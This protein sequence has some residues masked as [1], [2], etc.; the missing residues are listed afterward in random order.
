MDII[1][2]LDIRDADTAEEVWALQHP[3]YRAEA[4]LIGVADL[5]PLQDT[6]RTLQACGET[7]LGL[8][9]AEGE[10]AGAVSYEQEEAGRYA[11]CRMM[12]HPDCM[13]RGIGSRLLGRLLSGL[14]ATAEWTVTAEIRNVPA[15]ALYEKFGFVRRESFKP[16]PDIEMVRF[17]KPP[18][19]G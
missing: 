19:K 4:A 13:R 15:I 17:V 12:V 2:E 16:V 5:P 11:I 9:N 6:V 7:F 1:V 8:R 3:A 14:P 10:L 18:S